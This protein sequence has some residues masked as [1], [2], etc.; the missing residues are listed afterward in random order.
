MGVNYWSSVQ[1][2]LNINR[3]QELRMPIAL[4]SSEAQSNLLKMLSNVRGY[5]VTGDSKFRDQYQESRHAFEKNLAE[6]EIL[7]QQWQVPIQLEQLENLR[8]F[9]E[10]W[11]ELPPY[12]FDLKDDRLQS[13]PAFRLWQEEGEIITLQ[14]LGNIDQMIQE[15][16]QKFLSPTNLELLQEMVDLKI[17][18]SLLIA[19]VSNYIT[20][21]QDEYRFDYTGHYRKSKD[22]L[23]FLQSRSDFLSESQQI[24]LREVLAKVSTIEG[25]IE[26]SFAIMKGDRYRED[27][28][29]YQSKA[30]P[31]AQEMLIILNYIA[32]TQKGQFTS[33]LKSGVSSLNSSQLQTLIGSIFILILGILMTIILRRKISDPIH[34]LTEA[35]SAV[36]AGNLDVKASVYSGD[37]IGIL[38][39]TF[40]EM[41]NSLKTSLNTLEKYNKNLELIV[42]ERTEELQSKNKE[43][44][45]TLY[46]LQETQSHLIQA[47]KMSSLGQ[48]IAGIAHEINNPVSFIQC[49]LSPLTAYCQD[50]LELI[51]DC[52]ENYPDDLQLAEKIEDIDLEYI[53]E[54]LPKLVESMN[55]GTHR[56]HEIILSLKNFS[57]I[58]QANLKEADIHEGIEST[59]LILQHRLKSARNNG[60]TIQL[61]KEYGDLPLVECYPGELNQVFMNILANGIEVLE[62]EISD[63]MVDSSPIHL[64]VEEGVL[65]IHTE[66][67][68]SADTIVIQIRDNGPGMELQTTEKIFDPFFTTKPVGK[69]TGLGLSISYKII[70]EHH[71]GMLKCYSEPGQG[72]MFEIE[73]PVHQSLTSS[74]NENQKLGAGSLA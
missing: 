41:T 15:Q 33:E 16:D 51:K 50:L 4:S 21:R 36:R 28:Y 11:S 62:S 67:R 31:I 24:S 45:T 43:L 47:E 17:N 2:T 68:S 38:A 46:N 54:D 18:F 55:M 57:R 48:M 70:V 34:K 72:A 65:T 42:E 30:E 52:Q 6:M 3:T 37:E 58:D 69:G 29:V 26:E 19:D 25:T 12:L 56:I 27:L 22:S 40:N 73:I 14:V 13:E 39:K 35:T 32:Q 5:L 20:T 10:I 64:E 1:A 53:E 8:R 60:R 63:A 49:N 59:L 9:Y 61:Q 44:Q 23:D 74:P 66:Y 7:F 71:K